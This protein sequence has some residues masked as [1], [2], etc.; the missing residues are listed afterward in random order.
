MEL[1]EMKRVEYQAECMQVMTLGFEDMEEI[2]TALIAHNGNV[3]EAASEL[4]QKHFG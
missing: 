1:R 4:F 3:D 2:L